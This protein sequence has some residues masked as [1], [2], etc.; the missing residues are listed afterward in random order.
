MKLFRVENLE[1]NKGLW[2][3]TKD[4][5]E[6][7]LVKDLDM[8][9]RNLPMDFD[10]RISKDRWKSAAESLEQMSYWFT[11][12]DL[13]KLLPLGYQLYEIIIPDTKVLS[14]STDLYTHPLF[15]EQNVLDRSILDFNKLRLED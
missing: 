5:S 2:F 11:K 4:G 15:Q 7:N 10:E 14:W 8:S 12:T 6:S 3:N 1:T 9:G 13:Q